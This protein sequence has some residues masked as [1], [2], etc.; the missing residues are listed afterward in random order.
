MDG[1]P[2]RRNKAAFFKI[3]LRSSHFDSHATILSKGLRD[4]WETVEDDTATV[5][6]FFNNFLI[7][8]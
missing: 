2:N 5:L 3:L 1:R 7:L 8:G 4:N 6:T